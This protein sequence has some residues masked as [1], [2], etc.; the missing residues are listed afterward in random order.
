MLMALFD[1]ELDC[2]LLDEAAGMIDIHRK[3]PAKLS[4]VVGAVSMHARWMERRRIITCSLEVAVSVRTPPRAPRR[5]GRAVLVDNN[6]DAGRDRR[7][8][9]RVNTIVIQLNGQ[10]RLNLLVESRGSLVVCFEGTRGTK[11]LLRGLRDSDEIG[12]FFRGEGIRH[13]CAAGKL[14][15]ADTVGK[16]STM[17]QRCYSRGGQSVCKN[18]ETYPEDVGIVEL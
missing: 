2:K 11:L 9:E 12:Q 14:K 7:M 10:E 15:L 8:Q 3:E 6:E 13:C 16:M 1:V 18:E 5:T 4:T 17:L